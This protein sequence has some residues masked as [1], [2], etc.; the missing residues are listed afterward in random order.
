MNGSFRVRRYP[1]SPINVLTN[2]RPC[3]LATSER[4][5][6]QSG[7]VSRTREREQHNTEGFLR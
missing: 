7:L 1:R 5:T 3:I 4:P 2:F 6:L